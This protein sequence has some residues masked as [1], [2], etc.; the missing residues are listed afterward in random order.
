MIIRLTLGDIVIIIRRTT[1]NFGFIKIRPKS[2]IWSLE[3]DF[4]IYNN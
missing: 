1:I 2:W 4:E 3:Y